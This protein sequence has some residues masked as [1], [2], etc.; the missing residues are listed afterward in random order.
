MLCYVTLRYVMLCYVMLC[1]AMLCYAMLC[2][3]MLCYVMLCYVMLCYVML[4]YVMLC[5]VMLGFR[6]LK[7]ISQSTNSACLAREEVAAPETGQ[8]LPRVSPCNSEPQGMLGRFCKHR[9]QVPSEFLSFLHPT[10]HQLTLCQ[11]LR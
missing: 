2:Y 9:R 4:C 11:L 7:S 6:A 3:A 5:Y 10:V 1:Y 8:K